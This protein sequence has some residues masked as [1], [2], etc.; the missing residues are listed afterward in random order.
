M[1]PKFKYHPNCYENTLIKVKGNEVAICQ[2]CN[3][4]TDYFYNN[5]YCAQDINC[6]C[7]EC[8]SNGV[9]A[10]K[11][12]GSF[13]SI[14]GSK[15]EDKNKTEEL[16]KRT[17]GIITWQEEKWLTCCN[18]YCAFI[19]YVGIKELDEMGIREEVLADYKAMNEFEVDFV[20][21]CLHKEGAVVGYLY[22]CLHCNK[23]R[24]W[25]DTN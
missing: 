24:L 9:A 18:D 12:D 7:P 22:R 10:D 21:N 11:F 17:V 15:I 5:M 16:T 14:W 20:E 8:I 6:L 19:D 2:C 13:V 25:V 1:L 3:K 23:Y 4:K